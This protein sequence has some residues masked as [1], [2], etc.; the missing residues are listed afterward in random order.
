VSFTLILP[1]SFSQ[2]F[3]DI[4]K[5]QRDGNPLNSSLMLKITRTETSASIEYVQDA[6]SRM[7]S[8][9]ELVMSLLEKLE[10]F[11]KVAEGVS[12][13]R[14]FFPFIA[15]EHTLIHLP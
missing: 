5:L 7:E 9:P 10:P 1:L 3:V 8:P 11:C 6:V 12:E 15:I 2:L 4:W 14:L 13:V